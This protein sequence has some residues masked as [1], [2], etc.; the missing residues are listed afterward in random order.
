MVFFSN[1]L[2]V[3][4]YI[5]LNYIIN[6][7]HDIFM[8]YKHKRKNY[9]VG[10]EFIVNINNVDEANNSYNGRLLSSLFFFN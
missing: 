9:R 5:I 4:N 6:R 1:Y 7:N 3:I 8:Y 2:L 10:E